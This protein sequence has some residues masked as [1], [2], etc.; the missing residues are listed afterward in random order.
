MNCNENSLNIIY[1]LYLDNSYVYAIVF[2]SPHL[3]VTST[4]DLKMAKY[5][6]NM[7]SLSPQ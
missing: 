5:G 1:L 6:R 3:C 7:S 2:F 4:C